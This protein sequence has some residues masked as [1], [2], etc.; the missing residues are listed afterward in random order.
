MY[1]LPYRLATWRE[2]VRET[3]LRAGNVFVFELI[4]R[5]DTVFK[6]S[7]MGDADNDPIHID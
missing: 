1:V 6:V 3:H 5:D 7:I 4:D 2:F